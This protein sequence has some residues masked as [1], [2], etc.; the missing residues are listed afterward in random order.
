MFLFCVYL[1]IYGGDQKVFGL[2]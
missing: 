2:T 1:P